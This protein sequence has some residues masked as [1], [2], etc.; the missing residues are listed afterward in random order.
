MTKVDIPFYLKEHPA[1]TF[2]VLITADGDFISLLS[3][4][5]ERGIGVAVISKNQAFERYQRSFDHVYHWMSDVVNKAGIPLPSTSAFST[6]NTSAVEDTEEVYDHDEDSFRMYRSEDGDYDGE[7]EGEDDVDDQGGDHAG[8][9]VDARTSSYRKVGDEGLSARH[10]CSSEDSNSD[11]SDS[12][13]EAPIPNMAKHPAE[14]SSKPVPA[15]AETDSETSSSESSTKTPTP[16]KRSGGSKSPED[17]SDSDSSDGEAE[18]KTTQNTTPAGKRKLSSSSETSSSSESDES[19]SSSDSD[20]DSS[21]SGGGDSKKSAKGRGK[22]SVEGSSQMTKIQRGP[23]K[24]A[25]KKASSSSSSSDTTSSSDSDSAESGA[26]TKAVKKVLPHPVRKSQAS[27]SPKPSSS[28]ESESEE[29]VTVRTNKAPQGNSTRCKAKSPDSDGS[30]DSSDDGEVVVPHRPDS[31]P[32]TRAST[33]K[34]Q[35]HQERGDQDRMEVDED[36]DDDAEPRSKIP[37][38]NV[39]SYREQGTMTETPERGAFPANREPQLPFLQAI[40]KRVENEDEEWGMMFTTTM[41]QRQRRS[42]LGTG[43]KPRPLLER[44]HPS[45][46]AL[47]RSGRVPKRRKVAKR[48]SDSSSDG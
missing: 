48:S 28:S 12:D 3:R 4:L 33:K 24:P 9:G 29:E 38:Q 45:P 10:R 14:P 16:R 19:S 26:D 36:R 8:W 18:T 15:K 34:P 25:R 11:S 35:K 31:G 2:I 43:F 44:G 41:W 37:D 42:I 7:G 32:S 46:T 23:G 22:Q 47:N 6:A 13:N 27:G 17:S 40:S 30:S 39:R 21:S 20:S 5:A 1:T